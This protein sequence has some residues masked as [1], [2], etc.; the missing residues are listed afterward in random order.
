[1]T[2]SGM[3][4]AHMD[5]DALGS[6]AGAESGVGASPSST[7]LDKGRLDACVL[8]CRRR[9]HLAVQH[10]ACARK[11]GRPPNLHR[12]ASRNAPDRAPGWTWAGWPE[13]P[14]RSRRPAP[15]GGRRR[16]PRRQALRAARRRASQHPWHAHARG[17]AAG[18]QGRDAQARRWRLG[19]PRGVVRLRPAVGSRCFLHTARDRIEH[20]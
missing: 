10:G 6:R 9:Q 14:R 16:R 7:V 19:R 17:A 11:T 13:S 15:R 3:H 18:A 20:K 5:R 8:P 1:M 12:I 4:A 2:I